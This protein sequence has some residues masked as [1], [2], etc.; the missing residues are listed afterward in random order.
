MTHF[1]APSPEPPRSR[2]AYIPGLDGMRGFWVVLGPII[3]HARPDFLPP[4]DGG[5]TLVVD[6]K[7][8]ESAHPGQ[9]SRAAAKWGYHQQAPHY[10]DALTEVRGDPDP[11]MQFVIVE[12]SEPWLVSV[13]E[14]DGEAIERGRQLN[15]DALNLWHQCRE[16][17]LWPG[18]GDEVHTIS[19]PMW[20]LWD[21]NDDEIE[22][23]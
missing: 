1:A 21:D 8:A 11:R 3:F 4:C 2:I 9:F 7:T 12:K 23:A 20:A 19:L 14:L 16:A 22:V 10:L 17:G 15:R 18:Y 5:R 13:C 6:V